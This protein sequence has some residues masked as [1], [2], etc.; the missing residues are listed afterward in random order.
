[1]ECRD[2]GIG[3]QNLTLQ[4]NPPPA[5]ADDTL[6]AVSQQ[7]NDLRVADSCRARGLNAGE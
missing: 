4:S 1:M 5:V 6:A 3:E 7:S 2:G